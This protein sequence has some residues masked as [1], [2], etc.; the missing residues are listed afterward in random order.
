M[1]NKNFSCLLNRDVV[2]FVVLVA[3]K[4]SALCFSVDLAIPV[5]RSTWRAG[6]SPYSSGYVAGF[7]EKDGCTQHM[8]AHISL[9]WMRLC[10]VTP[11][12]LQ[13]G[14]S[15]QGA[16]VLPPGPGADPIQDRAVGM[17]PRV[18]PAGTN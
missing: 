17:V 16:M 13:G 7:T 2:E 12:I 6:H 15:P 4:Y 14:V 5:K 3:V 1:I 8:R 18:H 10:E 9:Q 11:V